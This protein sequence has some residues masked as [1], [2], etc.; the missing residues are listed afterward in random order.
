MRCA[1]PCGARRRRRVCV[2]APQRAEPPPAGDGVRRRLARPGGVLQPPPPL[3]LRPG[4]PGGGMEPRS[5]PAV[6]G[7]DRGPAGGRVQPGTDG[8][9]DGGA[10]ACC[11]TAAG[12]GR[13][14]AAGG[15]EGGAA[16]SFGAARAGVG[17]IGPGSARQVPRHKLAAEGNFGAATTPTAIYLCVRAQAGLSAELSAR[18][19]PGAAGA[20]I[21]ADRTHQIAC[22][23]TALL[24]GPRPGCLRSGASL[25]VELCCNSGCNWNPDNYFTWYIPG[26]YNVY[27]E[28]LVIPI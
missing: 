23:P 12:A 17:V 28:A 5:A 6:R 3:G 16:R 26:I 18:R 22:A 8:A 19:T 13:V 14:R 20:G 9:V 2:P 4:G 25:P 15:A 27:T 24:A 11:R 1:G 21:A 7:A 10:G